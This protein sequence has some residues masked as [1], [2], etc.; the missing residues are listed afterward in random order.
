MVQRADGCVGD[1]D[2]VIIVV[3]AHERHH[4][5]TI[6]QHEPQRICEEPRVI[7]PDGQR[8]GSWRLFNPNGRAVA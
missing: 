1:R 6:G 5:G 3:G 8:Q 7:Y 2:P 4:L